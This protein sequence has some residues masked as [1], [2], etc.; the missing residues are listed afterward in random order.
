M[1]Q[2]LIANAKSAL[3]A[4]VRATAGLNQEQAQES[5]EMAGESTQEVL[6]QE[7]KQG[8]IQ[9]IVELFSGRQPSNSSHPLKEKIAGRLISKLTNR[10]GLSKEAATRVEQVVIPFLL[11]TLNKRAGG[12]GGAPTSQQI[13]SMLMGSDRLSKD[14]KDKVKKGL[15]GLF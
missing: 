2:E 9:Q 13:L 1:W 5:V 8:N 4:D 14:L 7:V 10:L 3:T 12:S 15:G 6:S 11:D